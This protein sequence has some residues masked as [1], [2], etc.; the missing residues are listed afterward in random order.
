MGIPNRHGHYRSPTYNSWASMVQRCTNPA[1][2]N[3]RHY[4][5]RGI[6]V[7]ES[8]RADFVAFLA[9]MGERPDGCTLERNDTNG[10]YEPSNCRWAT[11]A[12]QMA[13]RQH[14]HSTHCR[15]CGEELTRRAD[16]RT[17]CKPCARA[18]ARFSRARKANYN[19][20]ELEAAPVSTGSVELP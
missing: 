18:A 16:G 8:W 11:F 3:Y 12:E 14:R 2:G 9:D 10:N 5:A 13:S 17:R 19:S 6:Q 4:G 15:R 1:R 20:A 7:C